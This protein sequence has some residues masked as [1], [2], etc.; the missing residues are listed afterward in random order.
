MTLS[1]PSSRWLIAILLIATN[2]ISMPARGQNTSKSV[3][4]TP[5]VRAELVAHARH[6]ETRNLWAVVHRLPE[7]EQR[8]PRLLRQLRELDANV[9]VNWPLMHFKSAVRY[10]QRNPTDVAATGGTN[11]REYLPPKFQRRIFYPKLWSA[12]ELEDWGKSWVDEALE[13]SVGV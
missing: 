2:I 11:W 8:H 7:D 12:Q 10:L 6:Y 3:V 4:T 5:Q 1:L 9:N 13:Q